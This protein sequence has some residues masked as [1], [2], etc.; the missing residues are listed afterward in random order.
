MRTLVRV[1]RPR[2]VARHAAV[3]LIDLTRTEPL[4]TAGTDTAEM[5]LVPFV[6]LQ[7]D[8]ELAELMEPGLLGRLRGLGASTAAR[9]WLGVRRVGVRIREATVVVLGA[10]AIGFFIVGSEIVIFHMLNLHVI[11]H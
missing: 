8:R 4:P 3:P 1:G 11:H 7:I 5:P 10:S 6:P 9:T 2:Y